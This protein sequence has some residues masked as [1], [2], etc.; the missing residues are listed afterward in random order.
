MLYKNR[1]QMQ[2]IQKSAFLIS[3]PNKAMRTHFYHWYNILFL[4]MIWKKNQQITIRHYNDKTHVKTIHWANVCIQ[5]I[6]NII[7]SY[8]HRKKVCLTKRDA[9][10]IAE[11]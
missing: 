8:N 10:S 6:K 11:I 1:E 9:P 4:T 7:F 5:W 2:K 3:T